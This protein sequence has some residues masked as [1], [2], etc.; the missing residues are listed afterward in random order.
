M[1][2][3][4]VSLQGGGY[5]WGDWAGDLSV[6]RALLL[7]AQVQKRKKTAGPAGTFPGWGERRGGVCEGARRDGPWT[8]GPV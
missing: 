8:P 1:P 2:R 4:T 3:Q 5:R 7:K 6:F